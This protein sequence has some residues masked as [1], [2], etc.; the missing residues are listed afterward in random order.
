[1]TERDSGLIKG[2][3]SKNNKKFDAHLILNDQNK[4]E[5]KFV[6]KKP[7]KTT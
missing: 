3:T 4:I 5:F 1:M 7:K 2:F 6:D